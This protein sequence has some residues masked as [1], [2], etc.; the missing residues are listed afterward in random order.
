MPFCQ[1]SSPPV[2]LD[3]WH[4]ASPSPFDLLYLLSYVIDFCFLLYFVHIGLSNRRFFFSFS[5][6][7]IMYMY[8]ILYF[9]GFNKLSQ[10][11][12]LDTI[13]NY[14]RPVFSLGGSQHMHTITNL[15]K[16]KLNL[17]SKLRDNNERK[18]TIVTQSRVLSDAWFQD[19]IF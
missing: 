8:I 4:M 1:S 5:A 15:C 7:P 14:Q 9:W 2:V 19:L 16:F 12:T 3:L 6:Q 17:S 18:N 11:N 13:G 10:I